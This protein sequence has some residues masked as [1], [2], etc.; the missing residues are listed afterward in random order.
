MGI[1]LEKRNKILEYTILGCSTKEWVYMMLLIAVGGV[2]KGYNGILRM[3]LE[4]AFGT[5]GSTFSSGLFYFWGL[6]AVFL[7]PK[8]GSA[9]LTMTLGTAI[10]LWVG[11]PYGWLVWVYNFVEGLGADIAFGLFRYKIYKRKSLRIAQGFTVGAIN[12]VVSSIAFVSLF[13]LRVYGLELIIAYYG[14]RLIF[15]GVWGVF[16]YGVFEALSKAGVKPTR[17]EIKNIN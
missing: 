1:H 6:L 11:N 9:T 17:V 5:W 13:G 12:L 16:A 14:I 7:V 8:F 10:E 3:I 2:I 4:T 15:T